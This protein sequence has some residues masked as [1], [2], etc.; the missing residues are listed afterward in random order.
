MPC[1]ATT[2][3]DVARETEQRPDDAVIR[4]VKQQHL[5]NQ[6]AAMRLFTD[7][8]VKFK[9]NCDIQHRRHVW[10]KLLFY[11]EES[12][13]HVK[14][15]LRN[16]FGATAHMGFLSFVECW[17][18]CIGLPFIGL[19]EQ[20]HMIVDAFDAHKKRLPICC[21]MITDPEV[22][23]C[24]L[25]KSVGSRRRA[26][27]MLPGGKL[28]TYENE[29]PNECVVR[30]VHEETGLD[31]SGAECRTVKNSIY[32]R[33]IT[34][35]FV[36][37]IPTQPIRISNQEEIR[38]AMWFSV[39]CLLWREKCGKDQKPPNSAVL[40]KHIEP[41]RRWVE[42]IRHKLGSGSGSVAAAV[43]AATVQVAP[44]VPAAPATRNFIGKT[45]PVE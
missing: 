7:L 39:D 42:D 11:I 18:A 36:P 25:V 43:A 44:P 3:L 13:W 6:F 23:R 24:V 16:A 12:F 33:D 21:A 32:D 26:T 2:G 40:R 29:K 28:K 34:L 35:F 41:L 38:D 31:I 14:D 17:H 5:D 37:N 15:T 10:E 22:S 45:V 19:D 20:I 1:N 4:D 27:W 8:S 9:P 30:E